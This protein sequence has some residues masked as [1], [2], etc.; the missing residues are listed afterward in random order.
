MDLQPNIY[1]QIGGDAEVLKKSLQ[2]LIEQRQK[3]AQEYV[4]KRMD[5]AAF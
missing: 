4:A 2:G 1:A 5:S 3:E